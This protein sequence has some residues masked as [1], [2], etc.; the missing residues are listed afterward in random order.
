MPMIEH[1]RHFPRC[2]FICNLPVGNVPI[3]EEEEEE[4]SDEASSEEVNPIQ[5]GIDVCGPFEPDTLRLTLLQD[6][7]KFS[8][9]WEPT[10]V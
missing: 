10:S 1:R 7:G 9:L 4:E 8:Y 2:P 3:G 5:L 6:A